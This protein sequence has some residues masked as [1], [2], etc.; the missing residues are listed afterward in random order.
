MIAP[1]IASLML[2]S[3][4]ISHMQTKT[5]DLG[6]DHL[7]KVE[8]ITEVQKRNAYG[9]WKIIDVKGGFTDTYDGK[10]TTSYD[11]PFA[12]EFIGLEQNIVP[13]GSDGPFFKCEYA[14]SGP[15]SLLAT[16]KIN[17]HRFLRTVVDLTKIIQDDLIVV[18]QIF[19]KHD[20][21]TFF[22]FIV[23]KNDIAYY[24]A[25]NTIFVMKRQKK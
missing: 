14:L 16:E 18:D 13:V 6:I 1:I 12:K 8:M 3:D 24:P 10:T 9:K 22:P 15:T 20:A 4:D 2:F 11:I 5:A 17:H 7:S 25:N 19:C 21:K 23:T